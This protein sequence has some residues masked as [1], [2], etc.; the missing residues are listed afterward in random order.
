M[1]LRE[2]STGN[3]LLWESPPGAL[4]KVVKHVRLGD[5]QGKIATIMSCKG[6]RK[7]GLVL[8]RVAVPHP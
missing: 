4:H 5:H 7:E 8:R 1:S 2:L 6:Q 3:P